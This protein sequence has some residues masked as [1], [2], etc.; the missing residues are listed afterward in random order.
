MRP[1]DF[2]A[3]EEKAAG[4]TVTALEGALRDILNTLEHADAI[5]RAEGGDRGGRY[6]DE[7]SVYRRE[8]AR[9][10]RCPDCGE[11]AGG[12]AHV[13]AAAQTRPHT[14]HW[15][16]CGRQVPPALWGCREHWFRL[17]QALRVRVWAAYRPGQE[18]T[19]E[20][21][22]AYLVAARD[23]REWIAKQEDQQ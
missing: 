21:S 11:A 19:G 6:R 23:V 22:T 13:R 16:G 4:M 14:C 15:P 5:D 7:A 17:P 3:A 12:V 1:F 10:P 9:R 2:A 8:L 18:E 20:L